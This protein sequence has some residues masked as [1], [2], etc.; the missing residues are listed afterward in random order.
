MHWVTAWQSEFADSLC[1]IDV[2]FSPEFEQL[3]DE[4][5]KSVS[6]YA[7]NSTDWDVVFDRVT[8][9][10]QNSSKDILVF[11]YGARAAYAKGGVSWLTSAF[12]VFADYLEN[13]WNDLYPERPSRRIA[14]FQWLS[15][16]F[17]QLFTAES[18]PAEDT[19]A[20]E[21]LREMLQRL[22]GILDVRLGEQAPS[23]TAIIRAIPK[24]SSSAADTPAQPAIPQ[25]P[26]A[27][28]PTASQAMSSL[29]MKSNADS[30]AAVS[31][32]ILP[33]LYRNTA[34]QTKRLASHYLALNSTD[35]RAY[36]LNRV[37]LWTTIPQLP[38]VGENMATT[39]RPIPK[40]KQQGYQSGIQA[41]QYAAILLPL[42]HS[43]ANQPFW[44]DGHFWVFQCLE[45]LGASAAKE[46]VRST[47]KQFLGLF[48]D[49]VNFKYFDGTP[50]ASPPTLQWIT[51]WEQED[52]SSGGIGGAWLPAAPASIAGQSQS[53]EEG[54]LQSAIEKGGEK[55]FEA[56]LA[57]LG[58]SS[59]LRSRSAVR[60]A[61]LQ[62]RY[63]LAMEKKKTAK[64]LLTA[65]YQQLDQWD[66]VDWEPELSA[67]V[68]ALLAIAQKGSRDEEHKALLRRLHWLNL[69]TAVRINPEN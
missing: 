65:I 25:A 3:Q 36:L 44:F 1:G 24:P 23:L 29:D 51:S 27:A 69:E 64:Q 14:A 56:G 62:A 31:S 42:E 58:T 59:G 68:I 2:S 4:I 8:E 13:S 5:E 57:I 30:G 60:L 20:H 40:D 21:Q 11:C 33:Q 66:L 47:L 54:L 41:K 35:W 19:D 17:E 12:N 16:K 37:A 18:F 28:P 61:L 15:S 49:I 22:Q 26:S 39:L 10:L 63:C 45:D 55:G 9:I 67:Q 53:E 50:F 34:D 48:P 52:H 38:Q 7:G 46:V 32:D 43:A 6:I